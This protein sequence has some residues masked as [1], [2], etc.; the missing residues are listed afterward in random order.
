MQS[1]ATTTAHF[2]D[3]QWNL[4]TCALETAHCPGHHTGILI[5]QKI[6]DA[7]AQ[8]D[9]TADRVSAVVHD[10]AANAVLAGKLN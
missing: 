1:F 2:L 5:S 10:E 8:Y 9:V 6:K 7:L 3:Q 4:T